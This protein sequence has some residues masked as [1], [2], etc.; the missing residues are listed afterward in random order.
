MVT[1]DIDN[2]LR[3]ATAVLKISKEPTYY[4]SVEEYKLANSGGNV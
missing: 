2:A 1:H 3:D 4:S